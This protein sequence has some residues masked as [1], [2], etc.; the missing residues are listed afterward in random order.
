MIVRSLVVSLFPEYT[1]PVVEDVCM[2]HVPSS[3][4]AFRDVVHIIV[5]IRK[6]FANHVISYQ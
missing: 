5:H 3:A 1:F 2:Y 6:P 4:R